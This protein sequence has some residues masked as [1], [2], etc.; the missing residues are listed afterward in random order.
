MTPSPH[1][2]RVQS[3]DSTLSQPGD[4]ESRPEKQRRGFALLDPDRVR[5]L[6]QKGGRA[7]HAAGVAHQYTVEEARAAG[8]KGGAVT[9][10]ARRKTPLAAT[11]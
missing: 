9:A 2:A 1:P 11:G 5:T 6:A 3:S 8:K 10:K 4:Q 7:A